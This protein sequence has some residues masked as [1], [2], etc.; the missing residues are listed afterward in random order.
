MVPPFLM[1]NSDPTCMGISIPCSV[2]FIIPP[3]PVLG[4]SARTSLVTTWL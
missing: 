3:A 1:R 4:G 2:F